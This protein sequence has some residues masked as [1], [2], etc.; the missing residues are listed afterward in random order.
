MPIEYKRF[1]CQYKCGFRLKARRSAILMH[2]EMCWKN[3]EVKSC[4]TCRFGNIEYEFLDA[5]VM[6]NLYR[7][8]S[9]NDEAEFDGI[10]PI[11]DCIS[12]KLKE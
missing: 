1:G 4:V 12:H 11:V 2:E 6:N 10:K 9:L 8:C 5:G 7:T 3:P